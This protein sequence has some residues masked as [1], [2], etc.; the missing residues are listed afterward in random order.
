MIGGTKNE[1]LRRVQLGDANG[2]S[3]DDDATNKS[4]YIEALKEWSSARMN[5]WLKSNNIKVSG[6]KKYRLDRIVGSISI[7]KAAAIASEFREQKNEMTNLP[8]EEDRA[9]DTDSVEY[10]EEEGDENGSP[11]KKEEM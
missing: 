1:L 2:A 9:M 3:D 4:V 5:E 11:Q 8:L 10:S 7:D 6:T